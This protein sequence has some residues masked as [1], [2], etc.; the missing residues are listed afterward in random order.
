MAEEQQI[1]LELDGA[2][3]TEIEVDPSVQEE[4]ETSVE[5]SEQDEFQKA[6]SNTQK[7]IDRLTKK[8]EKRSGARKKLFVMQKAYN[9]KRS[10]LKLVLKA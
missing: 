6:E 2:E 4:N 5:V 10:S 7:R 9:R 1:E 3:E 8:C